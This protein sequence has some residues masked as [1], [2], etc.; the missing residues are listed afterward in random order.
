V[1]IAF[2]RQALHAETLSLE[3]PDRPGTQMTWTVPLPED[4]RKLEAVLRAGR[5]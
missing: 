4:L 2:A 3:H 1:P 5:A